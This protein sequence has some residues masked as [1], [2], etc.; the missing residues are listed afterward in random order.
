MEINESYFGVLHW[1]QWQPP[2]P[3]PVCFTKNYMQKS[4]SF[5]IFKGI[6]VSKV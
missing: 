5:K 1:Q 6:D 3:A 2:A 4:K